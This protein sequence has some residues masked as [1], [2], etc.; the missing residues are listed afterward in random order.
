MKKACMQKSNPSKPGEDF[1]NTNS[2]ALNVDDN[3]ELRKKIINQEKD[4]EFLKS[5]LLMLEKILLSRP[6]GSDFKKIQKAE[7]MKLAKHTSMELEEVEEESESKSDSG[8]PMLV[9]DEEYS[10][11]RNKKRASYTMKYKQKIILLYD[12]LKSC[13]KVSLKTGVP[14]TCVHDWVKQRNEIS[15]SLVSKQSKRQRLPGGGRKPYDEEIEEFLFNWITE[16]RKKNLQVSFKR[17]L[18]F[19][20]ATFKDSKLTFSYGWLRKFMKRKNFS[21]RKRTKNNY[22]DPNKITKGISEFFSSL[23]DYMIL[24]KH[25]E[26]LF[27]MDETRYLLS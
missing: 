15:Q 8:E 18:I 9:K 7:Q 5:K 19:A 10:N 1:S 3:E 20:R 16:Q 17:L 21:Y 24:N 13:R 22:V 2:V 12:E 4:I 14:R 11:K 25:K 23:Y 6:E 27:N 26:L